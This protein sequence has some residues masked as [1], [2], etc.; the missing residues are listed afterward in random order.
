MS[1]L[2]IISDHFFPDAASTEEPATVDCR[3]SLHQ[4]GT[5]LLPQEATEGTPT[6]SRI[7]NSRILCTGCLFSGDNLDINGGRDWPLSGRPL[8]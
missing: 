7:A 8:S 6:L 3:P 4:M 5:V 1:V 2:E